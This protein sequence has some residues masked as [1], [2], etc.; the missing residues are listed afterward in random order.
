MPGF[1]GRRIPACIP[2][3]LSG[4][5]QHERRTSTRDSP[6]VDQFQHPTRKI[7]R[8]FT[9]Q[10]DSRAR[11]SFATTRESYTIPTRHRRS[12]MD[13]IERIFGVSPDGG[14][15]T[16]E[17]LYLVSIAAAIAV[18]SREFYRRRKLRQT[19]DESTD[20]AE[21]GRLTKTAKS[22]RWA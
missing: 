7:D 3:C 8:R 12:S 21:P 10:R 5:V 18:I 13:F 6:H 19:R 20:K 22:Q 2:C 9:A 11:A 14:N 4:P 17:L 15:G 1:L 16:L